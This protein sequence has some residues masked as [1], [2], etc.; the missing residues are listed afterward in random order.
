MRK[1]RKNKMLLRAENGE[2]F[3]K[4]FLKVYGLEYTSIEQHREKE[5]FNRTHKIK[6]RG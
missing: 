5:Y 1:I 6:G 3:A 4:E 2:V